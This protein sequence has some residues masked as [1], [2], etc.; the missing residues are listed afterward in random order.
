MHICHYSYS[1]VF[2]FVILYYS[3]LKYYTFYIAYNKSCG[4]VHIIG[5]EVQDSR[6]MI[7]MKLSCTHLDKKDFFGKVASYIAS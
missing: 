4:V 6:Y 3:Y 7:A 1:Y 2:V 5:E